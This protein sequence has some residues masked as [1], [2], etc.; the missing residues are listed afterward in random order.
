MAQQFGRLKVGL[1]VKIQRSNGIIQDASITELFT[2][3]SSVRAEWLE[4]TLCKAKEI[5]I[6]SLLLLNPQL[7]EKMPPSHLPRRN[8]RVPRRESALPRNGVGKES[9]L[10]FTSKC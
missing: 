1:I 7:V 6:E 5:D 2:D 9:E 3:K 10:N 4:D 8:S